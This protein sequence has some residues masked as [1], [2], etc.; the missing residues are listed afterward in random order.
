MSGLTV[1]QALPLGLLLVRGISS[2]LYGVGSSGV[3][4]MIGVSIVLGATSLLAAFAPASR[5]ARTDPM[6][7]LRRG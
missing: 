7:I 4:E 5:A 3:P 2:V 1:V 6:S